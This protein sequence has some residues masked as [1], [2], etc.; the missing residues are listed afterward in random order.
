M[1]KHIA[2]GRELAA[3]SWGGDGLG[4]S[5]PGQTGQPGENLVAVDARIGP[6]EVG[7]V[8]VLIFYRC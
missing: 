2:I 6:A 3:L 4:R 5:G 8:S 1:A 7:N